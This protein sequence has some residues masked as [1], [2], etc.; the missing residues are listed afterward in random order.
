MEGGV[1]MRNESEVLN[2]L[3]N[4]AQSNDRVRAVLLNGSR[5]NSNVKQDIFCDYDIIFVVTEPSYFLQKRDWIQNFG[6]LIILQQNTLHDHNEEG[7]IFLMLFT[8]GIRIDLSFRDAMSINNYIDD[9]LTKVLLDKDNFIKELDSPNDSSYFTRKP[10]QSEYEDVVNDIWW[11]S[12]NVAKG[13]RREELPYAKYMFD[14]VVRDGMVK[15]LAW[16]VGSN[17][18][19][20]INT[21]KAGRWLED[22]LPAE[23]WEEFASTYA[24]ADYSE[25]WDALIRAGRLTRKVGIELADKL[26]YEYPLEEDRNVMEYLNKVRFL[27]KDAAEVIS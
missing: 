1:N 21:G 10:V 16:Y 3:I 8:D 9:S 19:W 23:V 17:H 26:G 7:Y 14:V 18:D 27:P 24:G 6:E 22:F 11:C 2:Q 5:V 13:L 25:I 15:M 12:T 4:Y 20:C